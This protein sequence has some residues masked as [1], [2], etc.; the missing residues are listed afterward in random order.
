M[1]RAAIM[2]VAVALLATTATAENNAKIASLACN[3]TLPHL[4]WST[5]NETIVS[6]KALGGI[7]QKVRGGSTAEVPGRRGAHSRHVRSM[8][9]AALPSACW[10]LAPWMTSSWLCWIAILK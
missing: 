10:P 5:H 2:C 1:F 9:V 4:R 6:L 3:A 7:Y 8:L